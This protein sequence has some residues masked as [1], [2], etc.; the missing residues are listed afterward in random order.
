[1]QLTITTPEKMVLDIAIT[2]VKA[3]AVDGWLGI[4]SRHIPMVTPL[5][6]SALRY[7]AGGVETTVAVMGGLL[8]TDGITVTILCDRAET[9]TDI[10]VL[11]AQH[12][13]TRAEERLAQV[14]NIQG[15]NIDRAQLA[16]ARA[17]ARLATAS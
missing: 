11:R 2:S 12:A 15:V 13:K 16:L 9:K 4:L 10:D 7:N 17:M 3:Q 5:K 1:M 14:S 8:Q 6:I